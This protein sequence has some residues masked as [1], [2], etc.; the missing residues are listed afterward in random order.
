MRWYVRLPKGL[1]PSH[2]QTQISRTKCPPALPPSPTSLPRIGTDMPES[3]GERKHALCY[4]V[5]RGKGREGKGREGKERNKRG[6]REEMEGKGERGICT[7]IDSHT[8]TCWI[9]MGL[10][11]CYLM[12]KS[13]LCYPSRRCKKYFHVQQEEIFPRIGRNLQ[14]I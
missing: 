2:K 12:P 14:T 4:N 8:C 1:S 3:Y 6:R 10:W 11:D 13:G 9:I 7:D 5:R